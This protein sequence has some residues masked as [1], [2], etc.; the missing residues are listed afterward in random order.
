MKNEPVV[1]VGRMTGVRGSRS[2]GRRRHG[3]TPSPGGASGRLRHGQRDVCGAGRRSG[4]R[5]C[6]RGAG[7][8]VGQEVARQIVPASPPGP[9]ARGRAVAPQNQAPLSA[10]WWRG[11]A[12][13]CFR[14][15]VSRREAAGAAW[16][17]SLLCYYAGRADVD[18]I[19]LPLAL[20]SACLER[21]DP[22][23][24]P[25]EGYAPERVDQLDPGKAVHYNSACQSRY[26]VGIPRPGRRG[27]YWLRSSLVRTRPSRRP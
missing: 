13:G 27:T 2:R 4:W 6:L 3:G 1:G 10:R 12:Q 14:T 26:S 17:S 18:C 19:L 7:D 23:F 5:A 11:R 8:V 20:D 22:L 16:L 21:E 24:L 9:G 15:E 25:R